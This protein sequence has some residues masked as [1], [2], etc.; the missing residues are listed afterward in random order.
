MTT[1]Q[2]LHPVASWA[3]LVAVLFAVAAGACV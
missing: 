2:T 1:T 3:I